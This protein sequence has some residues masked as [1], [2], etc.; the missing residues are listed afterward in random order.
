MSEYLVIQYLYEVKDEVE[1]RNDEQQNLSSFFILNSSSLQVMSS[2]WIEQLHYAAAQG[3]DL[4]IY[5]LIKQ[6]PEENAPLAV[7]LTDLVDNF[8]FERITELAQS[9]ES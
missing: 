2:E 9:I 1:S 3:S 6:I 8:Q 4:L 7:A 5:Q